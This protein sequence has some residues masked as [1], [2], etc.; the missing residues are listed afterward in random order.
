[1]PG[2]CELG[3]V[4]SGGGARGIAHIGV[5]EVL[6]ANGIIP[7]CIAGAS[8]GAVIGALYASGHTIAE[9]R[10]LVD[11]LTWRDI[12]AEPQDRRRQPIATWNRLSRDPKLSGS[13]PVR[14]KEHFLSCFANRLALDPL[15]CVLQRVPFFV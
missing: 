4:L 13:R 12:Y 5:L 7:D 15:I 2:G 3:L 9:I 11:L 14:N 1:M 8:M 6:E 10:D